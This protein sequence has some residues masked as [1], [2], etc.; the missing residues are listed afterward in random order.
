MHGFSY[1]TKMTGSFHLWFIC[2]VGWMDVRMATSS[3]WEYLH[4]WQF[5]HKLCS[6][7][8]CNYLFQHLLYIN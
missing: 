3:V 5:C 8:T 2:P 4:S 1:R 6:F 7:Y